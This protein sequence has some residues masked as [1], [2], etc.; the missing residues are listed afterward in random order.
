MRTE[1]HRNR[2]ATEEADATTFP[3]RV[4]VWRRR[5]RLQR[6]P[7]DLFVE[8]ASGDAPAAHPPI[9][10]VVDEFADRLVQFIERKEPAVPQARQNP[11]LHDLNTDLDLCLGDRGQL[12][13]V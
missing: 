8:R 7:V 4:F 10:Q 12:Q 9:V 6:V 3:V 2:D 11:A 13:A 1:G 5:Q